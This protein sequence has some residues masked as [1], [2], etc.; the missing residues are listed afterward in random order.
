[1]ASMAT[2]EPGKLIIPPRPPLEKGGWG[3]FEF[4]SVICDWCLGF[5]WHLGFGAWDFNYFKG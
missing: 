1:M 5:I 3:G 2:V 4:V